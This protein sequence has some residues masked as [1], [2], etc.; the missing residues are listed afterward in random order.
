M[1]CTVLLRA[2]QQTEFA[3]SISLLATTIFLLLERLLRSWFFALLALH[4]RL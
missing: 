4:P 1:P 2:L 3:S